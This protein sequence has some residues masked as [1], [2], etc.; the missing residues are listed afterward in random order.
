MTEKRRPLTRREFGF[1]I[2]RQD[3]WCG[4]GCKRRLDFSKP[5]LVTDEHITPIFSTPKGVDPNRIEN[6]ALWLSE[7][8]KPKTIKESP[9]RA[10]V[11]RIEGGKTQADKRAQKKA[12]GRYKPIAGRGFAG[13]R[14]FNGEIL[15]KT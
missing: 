2:I 7:C 4:C 5:K 12:E 8:S 6:R 10:K 11:R 13:S 14:R 15:W 3:G 9:D 1:L